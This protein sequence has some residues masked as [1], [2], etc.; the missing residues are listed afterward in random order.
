MAVGR[1]NMRRGMGGHKIKVPKGTFKR[2]IKYVFKRMY[3]Q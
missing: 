1:M 3:L 2:L